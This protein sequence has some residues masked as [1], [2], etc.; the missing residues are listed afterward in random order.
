M[1]VNSPYITNS[2]SPLNVLDRY[3]N[4]KCFRNILYLQTNLVFLVSI[5]KEVRYIRNVLVKCEEENENM[6]ESMVPKTLLLPLGLQV[7][8]IVQGCRIHSVMHQPA[9]N[10]RSCSVAQC[11]LGNCMPFDWIYLAGSDI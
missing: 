2:K 8:L 11:S 5:E 9:S 10:H 6:Y 7:F 4:I 1:I 3:P